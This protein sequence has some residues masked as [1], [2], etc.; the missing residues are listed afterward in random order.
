MGRK[1]SANR[2]CGDRLAE[3]HLD[4]S[5]DVRDPH[6]LCL[7]GEG[8]DDRIEDPARTARPQPP[9]HDRARLGTAASQSG[10][11]LGQMGQGRPGLVVR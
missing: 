10:Q 1:N 4:R 3:Q 5:V 6:R 9:A 7:I 2:V 8:S 11:P